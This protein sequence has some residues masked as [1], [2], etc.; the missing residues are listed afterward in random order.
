MVCTDSVL[1][2]NFFSCGMQFLL[3]MRRSIFYE[4]IKVVFVFGRAIIIDYLL[5]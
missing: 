2:S 3:N 4:S 1:V 5:G